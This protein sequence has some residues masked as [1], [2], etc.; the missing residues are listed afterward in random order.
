MVLLCFRTVGTS[1]LGK[2]AIS[3]EIQGLYT[4][5]QSLMQTS[6]KTVMQT[7]TSNSTTTVLIILL[8]LLTFPIWIGLIGGLFGLIAGLFGVVFGIIGAVFGAVFGAFGAVFGALFN[9]G[10]WDFHVPFW[11][12]R[13]LIIVALVILLIVA[14]RRR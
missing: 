5:A 10:P 3:S 9:W 12:G 8:V 2:T 4:N 14:A 1:H 11:N 6:E 13:V 7:R